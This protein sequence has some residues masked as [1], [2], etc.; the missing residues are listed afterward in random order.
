MRN[1][2]NGFIIFYHEKVVTFVAKETLFALQQTFK[3][4]RWSVIN[5]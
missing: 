5:V 4:V 2:A 1:I 3:N